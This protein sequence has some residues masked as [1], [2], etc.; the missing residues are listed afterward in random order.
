[1]VDGLD[2]GDNP[3]PA[4]RIRRRRP[5]RRPRQ[6]RAQIAQL[7]Q[8]RCGQVQFGLAGME[9]ALEPLR[10]LGPPVRQVEV[11]RP[12]QFQ[13]RSSGLRIQAERA[14][15]N[16]SSMSK[17]PTISTSIRVGRCKVI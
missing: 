17:K 6:R 14:T 8:S 13:M 1:M 10:R 4:P 12:P 16:S 15:A 2:R 9:L 5:L 11:A 3:R 7:L